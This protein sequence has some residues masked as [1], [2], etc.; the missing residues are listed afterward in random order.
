MLLQERVFIAL[1]C[2]LIGSFNHLPE[3]LQLC[4]VHFYPAW[5]VNVFVPPNKAQNLVI[6]QKAD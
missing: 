5:L 1:E 6:Q 2:H 4:R 3:T